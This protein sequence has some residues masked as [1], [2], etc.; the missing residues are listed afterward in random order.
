MHLSSTKDS[1]CARHCANHLPSSPWLQRVLE[2]SHPHLAYA[3]AS[4]YRGPPF[5]A[6]CSVL[7]GTGT[8]IQHGPCP[9]GAEREED[10]YQQ[11]TQT[12]RTLP[13][14]GREGRLCS[15][16]LHDGRRA[17]LGRQE[18]ALRRGVSCWGGGKSIQGP[19]G[20]AEMG[21]GPEPGCHVGARAGK[22]ATAQGLLAGLRALR[23]SSEDRGP[24]KGLRQS[25]SAVGRRKGQR[26][27][28][29]PVDAR[30]PA[31]PRATWAKGPERNL[32]VAASAQPGPSQRLRGG[33]TGLFGESPRQPLA[34][35]A[36]RQPG[37]HE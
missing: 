29:R 30:C 21:K 8:R 31:H 36:P 18:R 34:A 22:D 4:I 2:P 16:S 25:L 7:G 13:R 5:K 23:L 37:Q 15:L 19:P 12:S 10:F 20:E 1:P 32:L 11:L 24:L 28:P 14:E 35:S 6:G 27:D 26:Y 9:P 33:S 3:E 17:S